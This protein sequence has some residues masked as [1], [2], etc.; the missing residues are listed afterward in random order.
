[1]KTYHGSFFIIPNSAV[2]LPGHEGIPLMFDDENH[3]LPSFEFG[4][5]IGV[6]VWIHSEEHR[7]WF[8]HSGPLKG[9]YLPLNVLKNLVEGDTLRFCAR[10]REGAMSEFVLTAR[11]LGFRYGHKGGFETVLR[12][13]CKKP[14]YPAS[15]S[16][17]SKY[18][19]SIYQELVKEAFPNG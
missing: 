19:N 9:R 17:W 14:D 5:Q 11:Q 8:S 16:R 10:D 13:V 3:A 15:W 2:L 7:N 4:F 1:M 6:E 12:S 18:M